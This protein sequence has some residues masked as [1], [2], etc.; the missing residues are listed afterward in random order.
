MISLCH[1]FTMTIFMH[2]KLDVFLLM[3]LKFVI[4]LLNI[5]YKIDNKVS[6][7]KYKTKTTIFLIS[8]KSQNLHAIFNRVVQLFR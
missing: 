8:G 7:Q 6:Y 3:L 4:V 1:T 2:A 5:Y